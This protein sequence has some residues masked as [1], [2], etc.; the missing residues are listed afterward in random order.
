MAEIDTNVP[1]ANKDGINAVSGN[2]MHTLTKEGGDWV[3]T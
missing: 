2:E 1:A 3:A